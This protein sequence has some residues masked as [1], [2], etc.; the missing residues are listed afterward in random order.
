[1]QLHAIEASALSRDAIRADMA[2]FNVGKQAADRLG[3]KRYIG[4]TLS[5]G[6]RHLSPIKQC[7]WVHLLWWIDD[8][9]AYLQQVFNGSWVIDMFKLGVSMSSLANLRVIGILEGEQ[10]RSPDFTQL[11]EKAKQSDEPERAPHVGRLREPIIAPEISHEDQ[12]EA[13]PSQDPIL[14]GE[15]ATTIA[16]DDESEG[17]QATRILLAKLRVFSIENPQIKSKGFKDLFGHPCPLVRREHF[18]DLHSRQ[19]FW[20]LQDQDEG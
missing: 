12:H 5:R 3:I 8:P 9:T 7:R 13:E 16:E 10:E 4:V 18:M 6:R 11:L 15:M 19:A 17:S 1:M 20:T 14:D 2:V